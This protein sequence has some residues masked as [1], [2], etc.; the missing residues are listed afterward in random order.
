MIGVTILNDLEVSTYYLGVLEGGLL[1][2]LSYILILNQLISA[3][4]ISFYF[5]SWS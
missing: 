5:N 2:S 3:N 1:A 4:L